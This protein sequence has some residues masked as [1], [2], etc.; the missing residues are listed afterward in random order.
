[1][2]L[3][4]QDIPYLSEGNER[5][6]AAYRALHALQLFEK[7]ADFTPLLVG[8]IPLD[9]DIPD[10]DL[11]ILCEAHDLMAFAQ[12]VRE[13][14]G[15]REG[16]RVKEKV[17]NGLPTLIV[18][19]THEGFPIEIFAQP[20]PV[21]EQNGYRHLLAEARLLEMGGEPSRE[22]IRQLKQNG[23]KTEPAFA[24]YFGLEGDP[25]EALLQ[26]R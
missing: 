17:V 9:V 20:R 22:A 21:S 13:N 25:Y 8:T 7:L 26:L 16:F 10:S 11:D 18:N 1:M 19:F 3:L 14:F 6:Q 5:Q 24:R 23:L 4:W 12:R 2:S 15:E